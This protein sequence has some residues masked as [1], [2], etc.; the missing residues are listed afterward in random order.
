MCGRFALFAS[1]EALARLFGL[2]EAPALEP[3][4]NVAPTQN[5][6]AMRVKPETRKRELTLLR[7]G[8][9]PFWAQ[10][11][12]IG[13]RLINARSETAAD[14]PA[15]RR[16][17]HARRCLV[18]ADGFYEWRRSERRR[19]QPHFIRMRREEPF[20]I[21]GLWEEWQGP[22]GVVVASCALL[23]TDANE[24]VRPLHDRMPVILAP[25]DYDLWL[26]PDVQ[27]PEALLPLLRPYPA[28]EMI[29]YPV[30]SLVGNP[31]NDSPLCIE[32]LP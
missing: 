32:P 6:A 10:D 20:A 22:E 17:F 4:Y 26:D 30:R 8:L 29:A 19:G 15:F 21:A 9:I 2:D 27:R 11:P 25:H 18:P 7:W 1:P 24:L 3:R 23:T 31:A 13:S 14:R 12:S 16:A 5:I 28:Q